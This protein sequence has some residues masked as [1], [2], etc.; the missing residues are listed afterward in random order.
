MHVDLFR[1]YAAVHLLIVT[2]CICRFVT[3]RT[4]SDDLSAKKEDVELGL[5]DVHQQIQDYFKL[6]NEVF[7]WQI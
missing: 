6:N 1:T 2:L 4:N 3:D 7:V 5:R